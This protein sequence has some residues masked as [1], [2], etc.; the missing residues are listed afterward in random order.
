ML[1]ITC[2]GRMIIRPGPASTI[3]VFVLGFLLV[4]IVLVLSKKCDEI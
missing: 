2:H 1:A 4:E 3:T